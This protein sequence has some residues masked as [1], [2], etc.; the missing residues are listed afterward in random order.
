MGLKEIIFILGIFGI[1]SF[2]FFFSI[3]KI[4]VENEISLPYV[5]MYNGKFKKYNTILTKEGNF[6][7][8]LYYSQTY[9]KANNVTILFLD[10]NST[11]ITTQLIYKDIYKFQ[12]TKYITDQYTYIAQNGSYDEKEQLLNANNFQ[13]FNENI[14]GSGKHMIYSNGIIKADN[15]KYI[16]KGFK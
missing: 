4:K 5:E 7:K 11:F 16:I 15:I 2:P 9:F 8:L 12:N 14:D 10:K 6:S 3:K 1:I 13:F